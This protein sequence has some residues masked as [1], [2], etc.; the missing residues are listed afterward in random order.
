MPVIVPAMTEETV[1]MTLPIPDVQVSMK[2]VG[3]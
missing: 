2:L 3:V 1:V